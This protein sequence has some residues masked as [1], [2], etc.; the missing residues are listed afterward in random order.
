MVCDYDQTF[1]P[2]L[3]GRTEPGCRPFD[4]TILFED[5]VFSLLPSLLTLP[6]T[7]L[8]IHYTMANP[9]VVHWTYCWVA[10]MVCISD[11]LWLLIADGVSRLTML[12]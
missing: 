10:K 11:M 2:A 8:S 7:I 1:G 3:P 12:H 6:V 4:F 9:S 5:V